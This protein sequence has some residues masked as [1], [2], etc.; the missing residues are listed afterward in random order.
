MTEITLTATKINYF[1]QFGIFGDIMEN[2][3]S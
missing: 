1:A 3:L 2:L